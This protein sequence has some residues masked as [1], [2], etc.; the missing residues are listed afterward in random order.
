MH[1]MTRSLF[2]MLVLFLP[3]GSWAQSYVATRPLDCGTSDQV[4]SVWLKPNGTTLGYSCI[5]T[6][7]FPQFAVGN[8]WTT[9]LGILLPPQ[10]INFGLE[11]GTTARV[12]DFET[13]RVGV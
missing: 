5:K 12:N 9:E 3:A 11:T 8:G 1:S 4:R 7:V 10:P 13:L 6:L 2:L